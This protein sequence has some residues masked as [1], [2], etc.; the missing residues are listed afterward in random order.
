MGGQGVNDTVVVFG[1]GGQ[2]V[3]KSSIVVQ[4]QKNQTKQG[5]TSQNPASNH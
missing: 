5:S 3:T 4:D 1:V 2:C